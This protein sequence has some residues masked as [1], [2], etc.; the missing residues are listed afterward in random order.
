MFMWKALK[1]LSKQSRNT[2]LT[3]TST[4]LLTVPIYSLPPSFMQQKYV[5]IF[6]RV[7]AESDLYCLL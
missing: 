4:S 1:E 5:I 3:G 7:Y 2:M 6:T